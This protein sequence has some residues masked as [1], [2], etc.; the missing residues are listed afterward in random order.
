MPDEEFPIEEREEQ[1]VVSSFDARPMV[2]MSGKPI[3]ESIKKL[4]NKR[5][6]PHLKEIID[7]LVDEWGGPREIA[8]ALHETYTQAPAGSSTRSR[9][10]ERVIAFM[11]IYADE[12]GEDEFDDDTL[13]AILMQEMQGGPSQIHLP[14]A[15]TG[16]GRRLSFSPDRDSGGDETP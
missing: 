8:K 7:H 16:E 12:D 9:I 10:L 6:I 11:Q 15:G 13:V 3:E 1:Q 2:D 4:I 14:P 5:K